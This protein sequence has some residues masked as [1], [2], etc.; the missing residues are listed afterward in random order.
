MSGRQR[1][2]V[3]PALGLAFAAAGTTW[4]AFFSWRGFTV[5]DARYLVPLFLLG[6][7]VAG[8]GVLGRWARVP[9]PLVFLGQAVLS[10]MLASA[11]LSGSPIPVGPAWE[12]LRGS[13]EAAMSAAEFYQAP[14]PLVRDGVHPL[15]VLGG[16]ACLLLVDLLACTLHRVPLAGFPLLAVYCVPVSML[17]SGVPWWVFALTAGGFMLMLYLQVNDALTRWG[18]PLGTT[19]ATADPSAFGVR[20]GAIRASAGTIGA[21]ST[22]LAVLLPLLIPTLTLSVFDFGAGNGD[23]EIELANPMVDLRRDLDRGDDDVLVRV[24]TDD[25]RPEYLRVAVLNRFSDNEW[26]SGDRQVPAGNVATGAMPDLIGV[27]A[28]TPRREYEYEVSVTTDF[29]SIWLPTQSPISEIEAPGDWRYDAS[30]MDFLAGT[31]DLTTAGMFYRM[32]AVELA[33]DPI[34][35]ARAPSS[36]GQVDE[37][38]LELPDGFPSQVS[39]LAFQVTRNEPTRFE[40]AQRLQEWFREDG[41]FT[42][43]LNAEEGNGTDDLVRFLTEGEGGKTG[44]CEQFAAAMAVMARS[45]GIP[46]R[47]AVGFLEPRAVADDPGTWEYSAWDMHAWPE[48]YFPGSGWVRFE[49]T[50]PGRADDAPAYT[51]ADVPAAPE[52][53]G[54]A[55]PRES[56]LLPDRGASSGAAADEAT[57]EDEQADQDAGFP[58]LPALGGLAGVLLVGAVVLLPRTLRAR[59]TRAR[60]GAGPVAAWLELRDV[61][62]DLRIPWPEDRSPRETRDRLVDHLGLPL[63]DETPERPLRGPAVA[64]DAVAALDRIVLAVERLRYARD[65]G[66]SPAALRAELETVSSSLYGGARRGARRRASWWPASV[67]VRSRRA[68]SGRPSTVTV[69]HG[70][71]VDHVG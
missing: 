28:A 49:P 70:A 60:L 62:R 21:T 10:G 24:T 66:S 16:L 9:S 61:S 57:A 32:T 45:L 17:T 1:A 59:R 53:S 2:A 11:M 15:L 58:W 65:D 4:L 30:T 38:Y 12:R 6:V 20:T 47:V 54:P 7:V 33:P 35:M 22:A 48:L 34:S 13:I 23:G 69:R 36:G 27:A 43:D 40:Q 51:T 42:Y 26:S 71:V 68:T 63:S 3:G 56:E 8:S 46:A 29:S 41:G 50:P 37:Q 67:F 18:R 55:I 39:N 44:Y 14:V 5:A 19:D 52:A 31:K 25:P 64:P